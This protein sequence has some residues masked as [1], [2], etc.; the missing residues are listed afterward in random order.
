[1]HVREAIAPALPPSETDGLVLRSEG[2]DKKSGLKQGETGGAKDGLL[3]GLYS[4]DDISAMLSPGDAGDDGVGGLDLSGRG[5][6]KG[7]LLLGLYSSDTISAMFSLGDAGEDGVGGLEWGERG[8]GEG[9][10][11]ICDLSAMLGVPKEERAKLDCCVD[12]ALG[13]PREERVKLDCCVDIK[14]M[15]GVPTDERVRLLGRDRG[16]AIR[17]LL[18]LLFG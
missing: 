16:V 9:E 6:D 1:L 13:G 18:S 10:L 5:V 7:V 2:G 11:Y 3:L 12:I 8:G 15:L 4:C 14:L 17:P